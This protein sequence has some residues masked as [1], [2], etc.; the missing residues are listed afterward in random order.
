MK[1]FNKFIPYIE[2]RLKQGVS[3]VS[4]LVLEL[5]KQGFPGS[6]HTVYRHVREQTK[7][8]KLN[9]YRPS[10]RFETE[11]GEQAQVDWGSF[12]KIVV[13]GI[14]ERLSAF[15]YVLSYSRAVYIEF[16]IHQDLKTLEECHKN[17]FTRLGIPRTILY[18][19]MKTVVIKREKSGIVHYNPAF[20]DFS[21]F[22]SFKIELCPRYWPRSKGK[23]EAAVK[24][25]RNNFWQG[26]QYGKT[27][28]SLEE[29]NQKV[30]IWL[31]TVAN[32]RR[33][34]TT[35]DLPKVRWE[36]EKLRLKFPDPKRTYQTS[37]FQVRY[38]TKDGLVEYQ[39][40]YYS[41][42]IQSARKKLLVE[43]KP[44]S[45]V[46]NLIIYFEDQIIAQHVLSK[47]KGKVFA[48][49]E[50]LFPK[51]TKTKMAAKNK[52]YLVPTREVSYYD[53]LIGK[54]RNV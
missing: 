2:K 6:Y 20:A 45:G 48:K 50:H 10:I 14:K 19:N 4:K 37:F 3:N 33:H 26:M 43:E 7:I 9:K 22:Y 46:P 40:N 51:G 13:N 44:K 41:V 32:L 49:E 5:K 25:L 29:L 31:E 38:S 11:P 17:A 21:K 47:E 42:P 30:E 39:H 52:Q 24:Y 15:V 34:K 8:N 36:T 16:T 28:N 18:D 54:T 53:K 23:V 35:L 27:F 12:G 1:Q